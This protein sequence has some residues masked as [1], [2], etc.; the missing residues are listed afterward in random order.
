MLHKT[1]VRIKYYLNK[2]LQMK[3]SILAN[4]EF[5]LP[6]YDWFSY[7][8][9]RYVEKFLKEN[10]VLKLKH[11][12]S[13][14]CMNTYYVDWQKIDNFYYEQFREV[15]FEDFRKIWLKT[16]IKVKDTSKKLIQIEDIRISPRINRRLPEDTTPEDILKVLHAKYPGVAKINEILERINSKLVVENKA[17]FS[18]NIK[19]GILKKVGFRMTNSCVNLKKSDGS[20]AAFLEANG[21]HSNPNGDIKSE[22]PRMTRLI[23]SGIWED[24][25]MDF[26]SSFLG[27]KKLNDTIRGFVKEHFMPMY[28][29]NWKSPVAFASREIIRCEDKYKGDA[30]AMTHRIL[31][32]MKQGFDNICGKSLQSEI[33]YYTSL[34]EAFALETVVSRGCKAFQIY[35]EI[36]TDIAIDDMEAIYVSAASRVSEFRAKQNDKQIRI[37][38]KFINN[39]NNNDNDNNKIN[40]S[41]VFTA[42]HMTS[43]SYNKKCTI[44]RISYLLELM[45]SETYKNIESNRKKQKYLDKELQLKLGKID[46]NTLTKLRKRAKEILEK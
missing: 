34:L 33:F 26:Y 18:L 41:Y 17:E 3:K 2:M 10:N 36:F 44:Y 20:R 39:N 24:F 21:L 8:E 14:G 13:I 46:R 31:E 11:H 22:I 6:N 19:N 30:E 42:E 35:D 12:G 1:Q 9:R 43:K 29:A 25:S 38:N 15:P 40:I 32:K 16:P 23:N 45:Q 5:F 27:E 28:F 4:G 37:I 7:S